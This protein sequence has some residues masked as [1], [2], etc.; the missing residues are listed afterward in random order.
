VARVAEGRDLTPEQV[1]A[2]GRG[3]V[4]TGAQAVERGLVDELGGLRVAVRRAKLEAGLDADADVEL[5]PYPAPKSLAEEIAETL[6]QA[7]VGLGPSLGLPGV[8]RRLE[9][10]LGALPEGA[11]LLVPPFVVE[12]R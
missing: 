10:L 7:S 11:P 8:L 1:H 3:R 5:V 6:R 9:P 2:V 12:I 4:W